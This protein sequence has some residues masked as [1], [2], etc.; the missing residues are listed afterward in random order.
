M[1]V[2]FEKLMTR[3]YEGEENENDNITIVVGFGFGSDG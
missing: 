2:C 1:T 3:I